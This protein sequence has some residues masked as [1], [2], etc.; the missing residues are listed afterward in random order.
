MTQSR[1]NFLGAAAS[2]VMASAWGA[3]LLA[4][5]SQMPVPRLPMPM[6]GAGSPFPN[7]GPFGD[8]PP[9][10]PPR[11]NPTQQLKINQAEIEKD[12]ARLKAAVGDLE[13]E[14]DS[15]DTTAVLSLAAVRKTEEIEKLARHIRDLVRG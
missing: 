14:F 4:A 7:N 10:P 11:R 2:A 15:K 1:R 6:P 9:A 12:M 8:I 3:G 13:K 5:Q